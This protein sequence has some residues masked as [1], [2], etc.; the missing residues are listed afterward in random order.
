MEKDP[1]P[2]DAATRVGSFFCAL[3]FSRSRTYFSI[4][5]AFDFL[6]SQR[7]F[8]V[9]FQKDEEIKARWPMAG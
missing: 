9:A 4:V 1:H 7:G 2:F 6:P 8:S 5:H 3:I